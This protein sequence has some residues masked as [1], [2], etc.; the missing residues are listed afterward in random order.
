MQAIREN[1]GRNSFLHESLALRLP[2]RECCVGYALC[3][4]PATI[5]EPIN[6]EVTKGAERHLTDGD[7]AVGC[8]EGALQDVDS[9]AV[10]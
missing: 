4:H 1:H 9:R 8:H 6:F 2:G 3:L 10:D 5:P 7:D